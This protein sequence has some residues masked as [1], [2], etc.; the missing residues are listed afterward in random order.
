MP[1][2]PAG[3]VRGAAPGGAATPS[4]PVGIDP[5]LCGLLGVEFNFPLTLDIDLGIVRG[6]DIRRIAETAA[7]EDRRGHRLHRLVLFRL[8]DFDMLLQADRKS[9]R[10]NSS[11]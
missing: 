9:T 1:V 11:H 2:C 7:G 8:I 5:A 4:V 6:P 3:R 10:L